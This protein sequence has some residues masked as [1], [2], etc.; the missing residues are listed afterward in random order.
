L[1]PLLVPGNPEPLTDANVIAQIKQMWISP[2][3]EGTANADD[4]GSDTG[5]PTDAAKL[6]NWWKK[7][8]DFIPQM[9]TVAFA[10]LQAGTFDTTRMARALDSAL[11]ERALQIWSA[12]PAIAA[13]LAVLHWD[14]GLHPL[15]QRDFLA[16]VDTNM[17]YNKVD[18]V[19]QRT[20]AYQVEWPE[21]PDKPAQA[22]V[23]VT[24]QHPLAL[25]NYDCDPRPH[26][27]QTY[28]DMI[29]RCYFDYIRLF[30]PGGS[31][32]IGIE[33]VEPDSVNS[34]HG[35][36]GTTFFAGHFSVKPGE[37]KSIIFRYRLPVFIKPTTYQLVVQK[38]A[39]TPPLPLSATSAGTTLQTILQ[40]G[41]LTWQPTADR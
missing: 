1:E 24:Y 33:G 18:A 4:T 5:K 15:A 41:Q 2:L 38:Q 35:E 26:Y 34:Q 17:G 16:L 20:L 25:A 40:A 29:A 6:K 11:D 23:M 10:R 39:G 32:L 19:M 13:K 21:G 36:A 7:R 31:Q 8:K 37:Q 30:V 9:A 27:G 12:T 3:D 28:D 14:G 22:T